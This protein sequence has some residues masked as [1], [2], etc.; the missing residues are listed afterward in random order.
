M[1]IFYFTFEGIFSPVFD[2]QVLVPLLKIKD[3][4]SPNF[5]VQLVSLSIRDFLNKK[6]RYKAKYVKDILKG[7]CFL[8]PRFPLLFNF[9]RFLKFMLFVNAIGCFIVLYFFLRLRKNEKVI[10][11]CRGHIA[12]YILLILKKFFY[13][14][15]SIYSDLRGIVSIEVFYFNPNKRST[16]RLSK[17]LKSIERYV[18]KNSDFLSCVSDLFKER[19]LSSHKSKIENIKVVPCC[20]DSDVFKYDPLI[21]KDIRRKLGLEDN[22]VVVYSGSLYGWQLPE[23][24]IEIFRILKLYIKNSVFLMLTTNEKYGKKLFISSGIKND[25]YIVMNKPYNIMYQFLSAGDIGLLIREK[26]ELNEVCRPVKFAEYLRCG[27]PL[28]SCRSLKGISS[29]INKYNLGFELMDAFDDEEVKRIVIEIKNKIN[30]I[31]SDSYKRKISDFAKNIMGWDSYV[32]VVADI[33]N[34]CYEKISM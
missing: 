15:A 18:E 22:F 31:R 19:I 16:F 10:F 29:L 14:N 32:N 23:R 4:K 33:Y 27:L 17:I 6:Y 34:K 2:S 25:S 24:M 30:I 13:K 5:D 9:P 26:N 21:R 1:R 3:Q 8:G 28:L 20:M 7:N 12:G 11:H